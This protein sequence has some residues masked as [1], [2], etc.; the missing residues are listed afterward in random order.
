MAQLALL[1]SASPLWQRLR[2][3]PD[4]VLLEAGAHGELLVARVR[5]LLMSLLLLIPLATITFSPSDWENFVGLSIA[6]VAF[7][8]S[9][10]AYWL[11]KRDINR[12]WLGFATSALDVLLIS[13]ALFTFAVFNRPHTAVNSKVLYEGYLI[14]VA[15]TSLRY[16]AR[17]CLLAG[18]LAFLLYGGIVVFCATNWDL[19]SQIYQP[20]IYGVFDWGTQIS[21]LILILMAS[22]LSTAVVLRTRRLRKLSTRDPL[23]ALSNRAHFDERFVV[24]VVRA[25]RHKHALAVA[26][27]DLDRFKQFNDQH[28]HAAGD[29]ALVQVAEVLRQTFRRSDVLA[30]YGGEEFIIMLPETDFAQ[31]TEKLETL[32]QVLARTPIVLADGRVQANITISAGVAC[33]PH[34]GADE[35]ELLH[36]ADA[37]LF[38]AKR[39]GRNRIVGANAT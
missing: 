39:D 24:E 9:V 12:Q 8:L 4:P 3:P 22:V 21:R 33:F 26:M 30:R 34:D 7:L 14:A 31:A 35:S 28:G 18:A 15:A 36:A 16:D 37:R 11:A 1:E 38:T 10:A 5:L 20:F 19:N 23:T 29:R 32:R 17:I 13:V 25:R 2:E 6:I 27:L